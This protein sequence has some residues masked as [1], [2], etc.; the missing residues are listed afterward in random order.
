MKAH[1]LTRPETVYKKFRLK[2]GRIFWNHAYMHGDRKLVCFMRTV[3]GK[4]YKRYVP[5][6]AEVEVQ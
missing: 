3:K 6:H 1:E 2:N 5:P 4:V